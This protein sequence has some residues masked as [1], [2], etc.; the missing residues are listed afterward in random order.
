[1]HDRLGSLS[2]NMKKQHQSCGDFAQAICRC[3]GHFLQVT[4]GLVITVY[5]QQEVFA[6]NI[7]I[8]PNDTIIYINLIS[9][10]RWKSWHFSPVCSLNFFTGFARLPALVILDVDWAFMSVTFVRL[11]SVLVVLMET[12]QLGRLQRAVVCRL[13]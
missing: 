8:W 5:H 2:R 10:H 9:Y 11:V 7:F 1:M 13:G 4:R 6:I 3:L 12:Q